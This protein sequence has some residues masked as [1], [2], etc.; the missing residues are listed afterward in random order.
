MKAFIE[1]EEFEKSIY[2]LFGAFPFLLLIVAIVL[3]YLLG[4]IATNFGMGDMTDPIGPEGLSTAFFRGVL[5]TVVFFYVGRI[6]A[7]SGLKRSQ[8]LIGREEEGTFVP[9]M[10]HKKLFDLHIGH[11]VILKDR[12]YFEPSRP[13]GGDLEFDFN[14]YEGFSFALSEPKASLGLFLLTMENYMIYVKDTEGKVVG[15]FILPEPEKYLPIL[16]TLL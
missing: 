11:I 8:G 4:I 1:L 2:K 9:C 6:S 14:A 13:F 5:V 16:N 12:L 15:K 7:I 3:A 10:S